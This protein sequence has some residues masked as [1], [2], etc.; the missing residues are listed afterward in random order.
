L[1]IHN[2]FKGALSRIPPPLL[3]AVSSWGSRVIS[4]VIQILAVRIL[5]TSLGTNRYA[6]AALLIGMTNWFLLLD[7]GIGFGLQNSISERRAFGKPYN[8]FIL[9]SGA[10][11][12]VLLLVGSTLVYFFSPLAGRLLMKGF[13][14]LSI[15]EKTGLFLSSGLLFTATAIGNIAFRIWYAEQKG[16]FANLVPTA[17][18]L[19]SLVGVYFAASRGI[20]D[21]LYWC[22]LAYL[23]PSAVLSVMALAWKIFTV[24]PFD[25]SFSPG[26]VSFLTRRSLKFWSQALLAS[27]VLNIDYIVMSQV[28]TGRDIVVY[29]ITAKIFELVF[30][31]YFA[32]LL[33][34]W[35]VLAEELARNDWLKVRARLHRIMK[36]GFL[37]IGLSTAGLAVGMPLI[38][39]IISP[40]EFIEI[41]TMFIISTGIYYVIRVWTDT[42]GV[43]LFS[44]NDMRPFWIFTPF[45]AIIAML[46]QIRLASSFG[47]YGIIGG[48]SASFLLTMCWALPLAF[49][50]HLANAA[51][52]KDENQTAGTA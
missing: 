25:L 13:P 50:R 30:F 31:V 45:Q 48:L 11:G 6:V 1:P 19:F 4:G 12:G 23:G 34:I 27:F 17:A 22:L 35:P 39:K 24:R 3:V 49:R 38:V 15:G 20:E 40:N 14:L 21:R 18:S 29:N 10:A 47:I 43:T 36:N 26:T 2:P 28:L 9:I 8:D 51:S 7:L 44:I 16:Y 52:T 37:F 5:L 46:L 32:V 42:Y 33:A 41:P